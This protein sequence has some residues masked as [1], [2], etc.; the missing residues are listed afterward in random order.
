MQTQLSK[1]DIVYNIEEFNLDD[2]VIE[3]KYYSYTAI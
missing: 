1:G 2:F 3:A